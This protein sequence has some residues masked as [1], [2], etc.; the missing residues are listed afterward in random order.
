MDSFS[1]NSSMPFYFLRPHSSRSS[2]P[3]L[4]TCL[5]DVKMSPEVVR[6]KFERGKLSR[7]CSRVACQWVEVAVLCGVVTLG[8]GVLWLMHHLTARCHTRS[9][10]HRDEARQATVRKQHNVELKISYSSFYWSFED[11]RFSRMSRARG[12]R[13]TVYR[14]NNTT[15]HSRSVHPE[16]ETP[17][18]RLHRLLTHPTTSCRKLVRVGGRSCL[19][20]YDGS[21]VSE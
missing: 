21:K 8:L 11:D 9:L 20:A 7:R 17:A 16:E 1:C 3:F 18:Q 6:V 2:P 19:G 5:A 10:D 13:S 15:P 4:H 14:Y 12:E